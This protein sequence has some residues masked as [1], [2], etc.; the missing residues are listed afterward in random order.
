[1]LGP[2]GGRH[3]RPGARQ[4]G[5]KAWF[6]FRSFVTTATPVMLAGSFVLGGL[7]ETGA[8]GP[9]G[10]AI[11]P[12]VRGARG[13]PPVAGIALALAFLRK[14]LALQLLLVLAVA[15]YGAGA[16]SLAAFMTS[17]QLF[18][19]AIVT[20]VSVPRVATPATPPG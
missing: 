17:G 12:I 5:A 11:A 13:L 3:R 6:R 18:V 9:I 7:Y 20:A 10:D 16:S 14:E 4:V 19:Y 2:L 15:E 8:I 1:M